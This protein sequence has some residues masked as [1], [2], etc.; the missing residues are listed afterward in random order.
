MF[1][2]AHFSLCVVHHTH[3]I[4]FHMPRNLRYQG[5]EGRGGKGGCTCSFRSVRLAT[6]FAPCQMVDSGTLTGPWVLFGALVL[7]SEW[8]RGLMGGGFKRARCM[9]VDA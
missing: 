4:R 6:E 2:R 8:V 5:G 1:I 3:P 9:C 7:V